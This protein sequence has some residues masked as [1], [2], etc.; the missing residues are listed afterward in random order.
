MA[1]HILILGWGS[2][3]WSPGE[4]KT[5]GDWSLDGPT[6]PIEFSRIALTALFEQTFA[7]WLEGVRDSQSCVYDPQ[8]HDHN[9]NCHACTHLS[10]T[11]CRFF[12]LNLS[13]SFLF[14]GPEQ[15]LGNIG[16]GY[17]GVP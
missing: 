7:Q 2:L 16:Q 3:I 9:A 1:S 8:C 12:N 15:S 11:S 5:V 4:L 17:F 10:E 13:R 6:L 14:G